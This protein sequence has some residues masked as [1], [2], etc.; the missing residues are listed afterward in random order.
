MKT[1]EIMDFLAW[2]ENGETAFALV[3]RF[4]WFDCALNCCRDG[5]MGTKDAN[6]IWSRQWATDWLPDN[7]K[8][9]PM[10][11]DEVEIYLLY[12]RDS[13]TLSSPESNGILMKGRDYSYM[14][15]EN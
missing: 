8:P 4:G 5:D 7:A 10:T 6:G 15:F 13:H 11:N 9:R 2:E 12:T 3:D 1:Y 14:L